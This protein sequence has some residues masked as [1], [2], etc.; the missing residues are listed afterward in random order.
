MLDMQLKNGWL[1]DYQ[2]FN[3]NFTQ[4]TNKILKLLLTVD[5]FPDLKIDLNADRSL[6]ENYSSNM[7]SAGGI[8]NHVHHTLLWVIFSIDSFIKSSFSQSDENVL[9][10]LM[11]LDNRLIVANRFSNSPRNRCE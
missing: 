6:S 3:Q 10:H 5:L 8:Y 1:T 9:L 2:D 7:C 4:V 11:I